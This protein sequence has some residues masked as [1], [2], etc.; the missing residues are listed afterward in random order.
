MEGSLGRG[1]RLGGVLMSMMSI[2]SR[3]ALTIY[4]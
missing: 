4:F 1:V 2:C 3:V